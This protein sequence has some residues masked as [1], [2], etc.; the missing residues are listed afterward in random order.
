MHQQLAF[1]NSLYISGG[2]FLVFKFIQMI[3]DR[4][5]IKHNNCHMQ[6]L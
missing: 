6:D 4:K 2:K 5:L 3:S 1:L